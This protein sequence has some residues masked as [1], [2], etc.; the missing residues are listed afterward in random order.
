MN[1]GL[2]PPDLVR[3]CRT[4]GGRFPASLIER[5][6]ELRQLFPLASLQD[7]ES[8]R[9]STRLMRLYKQENSKAERTASSSR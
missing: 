7:G 5:R 4:L 2:G 9:V 1:H 6:P 8:A 3:T